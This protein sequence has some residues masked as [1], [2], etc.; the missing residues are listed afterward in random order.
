MNSRSIGRIISISIKGI[1][2]EIY[3]SLG[4]FINTLDGTMFVGEIGSYISIYEPERIIIGEIIGVEEKPNIVDKPLGKPNS[5]RLININLI[6]EIKDSVFSFGVS[7]MPLIFSEICLTSE[8]EFKVVLNIAQEEKIV[9]DDNTRLLSLTLGKSVIFPEY[10][11]KVNINRFFGFHFAVFGNTGAGKSNTIASILQT[12]FNKKGYSAKG[13]KFIIFDSNGEYSQAFEKIKDNNPEIE[14]KG[15]QVSEENKNNNLEVPVWALSADDWAVLLHASEKTQ[16]PVIKRAIDIAKCFFSKKSDNKVKNHILASTLLGVLSSSD[17]SPS[18]SDKFKTILNRFGTSEINLQ[19]QIDSN[20]TIF[21]AI[22]IN[23]GNFKSIDSVFSFLKKYIIEDFSIKS[24]T[25][26][27]VPYSLQDFI[28]AVDFATLYEGSIS[29]QR[30]QEYTSTLTTRLQ[31]FGDGIHGNIFCKTGFT[32]IND[33]IKSL[34]GC[35]QILNIDL[36]ALDDSAAEVITKVLSKL[37][38]DY[39]RSSANKAKMPINLLIEEAHRFIKNEARIDVIGY[40]I[41]E[42]IAKEGRKYGLL[43]GISSQRPSELSKTVVSQCSNFIIHRIQ[44][45]DD[46]LYLSKM[47]PYINQSIINRLTYLPVG[48]A[49][50]FG[51]AINIPS[52]TSFPEATPSPDSHNAIISEIWY[53]KS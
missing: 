49:L 47:V 30:I 3:D 36:S 33:Y 40:N 44:N 51:T 34:I 25:T 27:I 6:G 10:D 39:L 2:A 46:L 14:Y 8:E 15:I 21:Q 7:K 38:F 37:L 16:L 5:S 35:N 53:R 9:E 22:S 12:I 29:S 28:Y 20:I 26:G 52:L 43:L 48:T 45:P 4:S 11:I 23:Y 24:R 32:N 42:R 18:K 13:A 19:K 50:V 1:V 17:S 41:F 31:S